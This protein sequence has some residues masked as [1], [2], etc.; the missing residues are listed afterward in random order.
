MSCGQ[1]LRIGFRRPRPLAQSLPKHSSLATPGCGGRALDMVATA[2]SGSRRGLRSGGSAAKACAGSWP[3]GAR[4]GWW[5]S[6]AGRSFSPIS[7]LSR[8]SA[9]KSAGRFLLSSAPRRSAPACSS[10]P[11]A[12]AATMPAA[13]RETACLQT[14]R[15]ELQQ[16]QISAN[17]PRCRSR[18]RGR[19]RTAYRGRRC[20]VSGLR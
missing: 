8:C 13:G 17:A 2:C 19:T 12:R 9:R 18:T 1:R 14:S 20:S 4:S 11:V 6:G 5:R 3:R 10:A 7:S 15:N 16:A